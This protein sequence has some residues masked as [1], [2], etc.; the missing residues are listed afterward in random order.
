[1]K[2][3]DFAAVVTQACGPQ[4]ISSK[5]VGAIPAQSV[6]SSSQAAACFAQKGGQ[7]TDMMMV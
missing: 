5:H 6:R 4:P 1:M 2:D 7:E 3:V